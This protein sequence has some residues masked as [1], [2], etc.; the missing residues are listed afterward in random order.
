M[1]DIIDRL[2]LGLLTN[3]EQIGIKCARTKRMIAI[4]KECY[5]EKNA[6]ESGQEPTWTLKCKNIKLTEY[7]K[8][9]MD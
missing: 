6:Q 5:F 1:T 7:G 8:E 3:E 9:L 4:A 2:G